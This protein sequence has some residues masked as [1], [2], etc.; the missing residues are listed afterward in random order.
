MENHDFDTLS[1]E[2][3][4]EVKL[5]NAINDAIHQKSS[6]TGSGWIHLND[7]KKISDILETLGDPL[8]RKILIALNKAELS[9]LDLKNTI[10][11][12]PRTTLYR[13]LNELHDRGIVKIKTFVT[14]DTKKIAIYQSTL[15]GIQINMKDDIDLLINLR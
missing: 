6:S 1:K 5:L 9:A 2:V 7:S 10:P 14:R 13:K 12:T 15:S 3:Q 11:D 4:Q 8:T